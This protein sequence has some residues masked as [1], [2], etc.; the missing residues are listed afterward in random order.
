M[1][2]LRMMGFHFENCRN[3]E[4]LRQFSKYGTWLRGSAVALL[5][6]KVSYHRAPRRGES[7][8]W[9]SYHEEETCGEFLYFVA[10]WL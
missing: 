1:K 7:A 8:G 9:I 6:G 2:M 10:R 5:D 4:E 3:G